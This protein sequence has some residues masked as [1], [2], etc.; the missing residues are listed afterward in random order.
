MRVGIVG[1]NSQ[2][3]TEVAFHLRERGH[4]IRPIVRNELAAAFIERHGFDCAVVDMT[5]KR[6]ATAALEDVDVVVVSAHAPPFSGEIDDPRTARRT[7]ETIVEHAVRCTPAGAEVVYFSTISAYGSD[8]YTSGSSWKLY[9]REKRHIEEF[10]LK[11][12]SEVEGGAYCLRLGLVIGPNQSRTHRIC[13]ALDG[14]GSLRVAVSPDRVSNVLHTVTLAEAIARCGEGVPE[15]AVYDLVNEPQWTWEQVLEFYAPANRTLEFTTPDGDQS[16][17]VGTVL[18]FGARAVKRYK[19]Y[20]IPYQVYLPTWFNR[21][22]IHLF[23]KRNLS[24]DIDSYETRNSLDLE[25]FSYRPLVPDDRVPDLTKTATLLDEH[26]TF[27]DI[28]EPR[29]IE[30][31]GGLSRPVAGDK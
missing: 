2:V 6:E 1:G 16:S 5:E 15:S 28:F 19:N 7:N 12:A 13:E 8:L 24:D 14:N 29:R 30:P 25:A 27:E 4:E 26:P 31:E 23:R 9:A 20:L 10:T 21:R 22:V 3:A 17:P 18:S 11:T